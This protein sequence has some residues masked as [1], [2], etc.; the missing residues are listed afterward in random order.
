MYTLKLLA[1]IVLL[2]LSVSSGFATE[3]VPRKSPEFIIV[4]PS[5]KQTLLTNFRGRVVVIE[6]FL[7]NCPRCQRVAGTIAKLQREL[8]P[9]GFQAVAIA[10][11]TG[12]NGTRVTDFVRQLGVSYPVGYASSDKVDNYLGRQPMQRLRVPQI[13][14]IDR[15]GIIRA[16]SIEN[17]EK[18]L[19]DENYLHNLID[20][21]LKERKRHK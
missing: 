14:V 8:G 9:R 2:T 7:I 12:I 11:D 6:F 10:F 1:M 3:P 5:G 13:V 17:G 16:Q 4:E 21:L 15:K 20:G 18:N 19:E